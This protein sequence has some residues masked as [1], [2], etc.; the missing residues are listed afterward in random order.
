MKKLILIILLLPIMSLAQ[1]TVTRTVLA[2]LDTLVTTTTTTITTQTLKY[3]PPPVVP[4]GKPT[5]FTVSTPVTAFSGQTI[6][7]VDITGGK[8]SGIIIPP[9]VHD[10]TILN[11]YIHNCA[12]DNGAI[13]IEKG[14]YNITIRNN[15]IATSGRGVNNVYG[16]QNIAVVGNYFLNIQSVTG[17]GA[18]GGSDVQFNNTNGASQ[19]CDSNLVWHQTPNPAI[20]DCLSFYES[21]GTPTSY[22]SMKYNKVFG[23]STYTAGKSAGVVG[24]VSGSY[25]DCE[26]NIAV[27][28]GME[29]WQVQG[30]TYIIC[31]NNVAFGDGSNPVATAA[32]T[33]G[34]YG[35]IPTNNVTISNNRSNWLNKNKQVSDFWF[36]PKTVSQ[37]A[38]WSTNK[39]DATITIKILPNPLF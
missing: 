10:V 32:F 26:Y 14:A 1:T 37:P 25:Q 23:G 17:S 36:D 30:G 3:V 5:V 16:A 34:N 8:S 29:A 35:G 27:N 12:T 33:Y 24:D 31:S 2:N 18:A 20:G 15:I 6:K 7:G 9:G 21:K 4:T 13:Y 22:M 19:R 39:H 11:S 28:S 38:G